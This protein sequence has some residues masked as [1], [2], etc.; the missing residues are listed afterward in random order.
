MPNWCENELTIRGDESDVAACLAKIAGPL[1]EGTGQPLAIS[2]GQ[3]V[4][5][6]LCLRGT[7]SGSGALMGAIIVGCAPDGVADRWLSYPWVQSEGVKT[8][9]E[10]QEFLR[11]RDTDGR[12][13]AE[14]EKQRKAHRETGHRDWYSWSIANWGTKWDASSPN[15]I[16]KREDGMACVRFDTAW[17]PPTPVIEVLGQQFPKLHLTLRYWEGGAAFKGRFVVRK[18]EVVD[19]Q[20]GDYQGHRGG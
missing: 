15:R 13:V 11:K 2:F 3:I 4:P 17:S 1:D 20:C 12:A 7:E 10:L 14:A 8:V 9:E 19:D 5:M 6:P 16:D 18:G